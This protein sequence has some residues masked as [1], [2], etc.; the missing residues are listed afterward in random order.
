[1]GINLEKSPMVVTT[2]PTTEVPMQGA[3]PSMTTS[4]P[5]AG[6][7][8]DCFAGVEVE[9]VTLGTA[10]ALARGGVRVADTVACTAEGLACEAVETGVEVVE[11]VGGS[12]LDAGS[13]IVAGMSMAYELMATGVVNAWNWLTGR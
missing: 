7:S 11:T 4:V 8:S 5:C 12:V 1:M 6:M 10:G 9:S 13:N 3:C 2:M